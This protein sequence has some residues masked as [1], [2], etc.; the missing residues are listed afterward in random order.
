MNTAKASKTWVDTFQIANSPSILRTRT[1]RARSAK[2][3]HQDD[4]C[5]RTIAA[6]ERIAQIERVI[7]GEPTAHE[8]IRVD[9]W[10]VAAFGVVAAAGLLALSVIAWLPPIS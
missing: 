5:D 7:R 8:V 9:P 10:I 3:H 1:T 2:G 6:D 4:I